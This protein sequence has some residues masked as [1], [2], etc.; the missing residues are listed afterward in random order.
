MT[1]VFYADRIHTPLLLICGGSDGVAP[2]SQSAEMFV[3]LRRLGRRCTLLVYPGE[4]HSP[5]RFSRDHR[6]DVIHRVLAWLQEH[7]GPAG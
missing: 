4:G 1:P 7:L 5:D 2:W 6:D 3:A